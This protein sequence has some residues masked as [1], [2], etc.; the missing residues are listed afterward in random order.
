MSFVGKT[1]ERYERCGWGK[2]WYTKLAYPG[3]G[4]LAYQLQIQRD[5]VKAHTA[6]GDVEI[7]RRCL[8][9][10]SEQCPYLLEDLLAGE[11][12]NPSTKSYWVRK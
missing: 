4:D 2:I 11:I 9:A 5:D 3:L 10:M 1:I 7:T 12:E 8:V 6:D